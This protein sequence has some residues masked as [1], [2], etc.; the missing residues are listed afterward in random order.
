MDL[1]PTLLELTGVPVPTVGTAV[2]LVHPSTDR[3]RVGAY[4]IVTTTILEQTRKRHPAF[5]PKP[6]EHTLQAFYRAPWK[7][8]LAS[9]GA[10]RLYDLEHDPQEAN[11]LAPERG[12]LVRSLSADL[13]HL[14]AG[15]RPAPHEPE[16]IEPDADTRARL[17]A[18]GYDDEPRDAA[19]MQ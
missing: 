9:D 16:V 7:L 11:D 6:F 10:S 14:L 19:A 1:F 12:D 8:I 2:S 3:V 4:P 15:A 5:D 13:A 18:L 17:K